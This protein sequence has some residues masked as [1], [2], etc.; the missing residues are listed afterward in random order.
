MLAQHVPLPKS[1]RPILYII[2]LGEKAKERAF[3][4]LHDLR[5]NRIPSQ[6]DFSGRKLAK[7]MQHANQI[8]VQFVVVIGENELNTNMV[9]L[10]EMSTGKTHK[11]GLD[12]LSKILKI[13]TQSEKFMQMWTE[14]NQP[15][16]SDTQAS[17]FIHKIESS[18]K[19][20]KQLT[21]T[22]RTAI[23]KINEFLEE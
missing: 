7:V 21:D 14:M 15:F 2:P 13:E 1:D 11:V 17:Y 10:K 4:I 12:D 6:M 20:T 8:Q 5:Q 22:F 9:D 19:E 18:I 3:S 16:E 23:E